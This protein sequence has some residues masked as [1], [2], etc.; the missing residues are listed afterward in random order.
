MA[1]DSAL[2]ERGVLTADEARWQV[3]VARAK[4]IGP[5]AQ[6]DRVSVAAAD[7]ALYAAKHAGRDRFVM[8]GQV[9]AWRGVE[10]A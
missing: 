7:Q 6:S 3:A 1:E 5:L 2:P 10:S 8:S 4:V 9:V